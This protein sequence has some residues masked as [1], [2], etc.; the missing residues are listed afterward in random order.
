MRQNGVSGGL[1]KLFHNYLNNRKQPVVPN[2]F[3]ADYSTRESG[4]PQGSDLDPLLFL[5]Y[6]ND[7]QRSVKFNVLFC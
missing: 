3:Q 4:V 5:I 7:M 2:G 6:I 1:L